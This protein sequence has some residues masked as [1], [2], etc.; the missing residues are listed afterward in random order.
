MNVTLNPVDKPDDSTFL[1]TRSSLLSRLKTWEDAKSWSEFFGT[2]GKSIQILAQKC[3]LTPGEIEEVVQETMLAVAKQMPGFQ[4]DRSVG[5]FKGWLYT[6]SK[7]A[8]NRQLAGRSRAIAGSSDS[9]GDREILE[10]LPDPGTSFDEQWENDWRKNLLV[11]A[12]DR[13]RH[14]VKPRQY[15]IFDL[16][17]TQHIP[18][19][20]VR[21]MLNVSAAQVY[22]AK[23]RIMPLIKKEIAELEKQLV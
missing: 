11:L 17:V 15:Q 13:V 4:Y 18:L 16:Y 9:E 12:M 2:Y 22:I 6:I 21:R 19:A 10:N 20:S 7:S 14:K 3:S 23:F 5:S 1:P 8:I